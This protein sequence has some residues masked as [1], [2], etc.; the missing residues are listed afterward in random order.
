MTETTNSPLTGDGRT[1][2]A[3]GA[4]SVADP[5]LSPSNS[6]HST[7]FAVR[8]TDGTIGTI[9]AASGGDHTA[10]LADPRLTCTPN[11]A[12]LRVDG[13]SPTI[14]GTSGVWSNGSVQLADP[15]PNRGPRNGAFGVQDLDGESCTITG[16]FDVHVGPAA[17]ADRRAHLLVSPIIS[18][19]GTWNRPMTARELA[20]LQS[21]PR[22]GVD[23][24]PL[25][26]AGGVT[27]IRMQIGNMIPPDTARAI[28]E[29]MLRTL[30]ASDGVPVPVLASGI[31][32]RGADGVLRQH[33]SS[34][35]RTPARSVVVEGRA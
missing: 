35:R 30:L 19:W 5:R 4:Y 7:K 16:S 3:N 25:Q 17:V 9:T 28:A 10:N 2:P 13:A 34:R 8:D 31:W 33:L 22:V 21:V 26:F 14:T 18:P 15:R 23:G 24:E 12:S 6:R 32:V 27:D 29:Q 1:W 20:D 11:G